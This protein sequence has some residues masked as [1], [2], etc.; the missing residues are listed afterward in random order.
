MLC[1]CVAVWLYMS[2]AICLRVEMVKLCVVLTSLW[3]V[4][5]MNWENDWIYIA[6]HKWYHFIKFDNCLEK[7]TQ[8]IVYLL[9]IEWVFNITNRFYHHKHVLMLNY[10]LQM[11]YFSFNWT[12]PKALFKEMNSELS[13]TILDTY[14]IWNV[15]QNDLAQAR[16][17]AGPHKMPL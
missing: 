5:K 4:L 9:A 1:V 13:A 10:F 2:Q 11:V 14:S 15:V 12:R 16:K 3:C 6:M 7:W 8:L 17:K